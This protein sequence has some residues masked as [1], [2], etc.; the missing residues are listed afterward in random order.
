[1]G[2]NAAE[3]RYAEY[4]LML[5]GNLMFLLLLPLWY[6]ALCIGDWVWCILGAAKI[7]YSL[8]GWPRLPMIAWGVLRL[9]QYKQELCSVYQFIDVLY[10]LWCFLSSSDGELTE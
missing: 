1:M 7:V 2:Q 8:V 4:A 9:F 5:N 10:N 6:P 3:Q